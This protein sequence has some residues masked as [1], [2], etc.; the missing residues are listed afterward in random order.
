M[1]PYL[2]ALDSVDTPVIRSLRNPRAHTV[3]VRHDEILH[4]PAVRDPRD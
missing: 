3:P 4:T 2:F 1:S